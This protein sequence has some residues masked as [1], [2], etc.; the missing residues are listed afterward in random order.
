MTVPSEAARPGLRERKKAGT[1]AAIQRHALRLF[2]EHGYEATTMNQIAAA[3]DVSPSTLFRY[4]PTKEE[5][6]RWDEYDPQLM[7]VL[8]TQPPRLGALGALRAAL[9]E[10]LAQLPP[11]ELALLRERV[12]LMAQIP[13]LRA[14]GADP[15]NAP[16]QLLA[17]ALAERAGRRPNDLE[18]QILVGAVLGAGLA[19]MQAAAANPRADLIAMLDDALA[20]LEDGLKL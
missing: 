19:V 15:L 3:A 17:E 7:E 13:P 10:L 1:R 20:Q 16:S 14:Q 5:L 8:R 11:E 9:R 4:F 2:R 18:V 12:T 6:V